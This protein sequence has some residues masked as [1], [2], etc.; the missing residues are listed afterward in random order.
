M[1]ISQPSWSALLD[2][3]HCAIHQSR[4]VTMALLLNPNYSVNLKSIANRTQ[5]AALLRKIVTVR[6][7]CHVLQVRDPQRDR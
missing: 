3:A 2:D 6:R 7:A 4:S 5:V 1:V